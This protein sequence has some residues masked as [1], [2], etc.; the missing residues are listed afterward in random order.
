MTRA[1]YYE[2]SDGRPDSGLVPFEWVSLESILGG[3][4]LTVAVPVVTTLI[5]LVVVVADVAR[6]NLSDDP[7][8]DE[9]TRLL[10]EEDV[11]EARFVQLGRDFEHELPN[12]QVPL[13]STAPPEPAAVPT[14]QTPTERAEPRERPEQPPPPDAVEDVLARIGDRAQAFAEIAERREREGDPD[15]IEEGTETVAT[16]GDLYRGRLY[17]FFRRGWSIPTTL[18]RDEAAGLTA[19]VNVEIGQNLEIVSFSVRG[20]SNNPVFD[21]SITEQLTRLQASDQHIPPPP[22][23][24]ADQYIGQ[25]IAV[26][27]HGRQAR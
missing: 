9:P 24:V 19:T 6:T 8:E 18:S 12:R 3:V 17:A 21:Q 26:R 13:L 10:E 20:G 25:T 27:F 14:E 22:E 1:L 16:E 15:G 2:P 23:D 4:A 11:I 7:E 5:F